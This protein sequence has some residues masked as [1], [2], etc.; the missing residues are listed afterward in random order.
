MKLLC[1]SNWQFKCLLEFQVVIE[2]TE[3][4]ESDEDLRNNLYV[5]TTRHAC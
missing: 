3:R 4:L 5:I 2:M 1:Y